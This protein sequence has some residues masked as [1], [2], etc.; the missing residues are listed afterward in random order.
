[1]IGSTPP[2]RVH[3]AN[4]APLRSDGDYVLYWMIS[5]RRAFDNFALQHA[6]HTAQ[7]LGKPLL[8]LEALRC[9][10]P[11]ASDRFHR[12]VLDGMNT[13]RG[14]FDHP[15]VLYYPYISAKPKQGKGL[16][17]LLA[18]HACM[19]VTDHFPC[20]FLPNMVAAAGRKLPIRLDV[21]DSN[22]V[23]PLS[24]APRVFTTAASFRRHLHKEILPHLGQMPA[25]SPLVGAQLVGSVELPARCQE[26]YPPAPTAL[27]N[28]TGSASLRDLPI[29]HS[30]APIVER[31]GA[32]AAEIAMSRFL[33]D[34]LPAYLDGRNQ[35]DK[36]VCSGL[37]SYLHWGHIGVHRVLRQLFENERW[38]SAR[39][40]DKPTGSRAGWWGMSEA[41][42]AFIDQL[43][44]WRELGYTFCH[45]RPDDYHQFESL[46]RW[47]LQTLETHAD[48]PREHLYSL[49]QLND[50][51]THD[52]LWNAAQRQLVEQ[53][54]IHN[55]LRMLWG[56][57]IL[58]WSPSP[59]V[60]LSHLIELNNR[61]SIDGRNPNSWSGIFWTLGRFDRAWGP[62]RAI[63]GK[64]R[65]MC[66]VNTA[67][68]VRVRPYLA[69][70]AAKGS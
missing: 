48:D 64:V 15:G 35:P 60:A 67:R 27:L 53:G 45:L 31:G 42:E 2:A 19:V 8:V 63:F 29:D 25:P 11:W 52:P 9:D 7:L 13:N 50:A 32:A 28:D 44:T 10:Y 18:A 51:Q 36:D 58:Q 69:Q 12:F 56:K 40:A 54:R 39:V 3:T 20:F 70:W 21:V 55:Y 57:K 17:E 41:A 16:L 66:S 38:T 34:R 5:A 6:V 49:T 23:M 14:D 33:S 4:Q 30:V 1:M 37:S 24:L 22:G 62:E 47:S 43:V 65:Y 61:Y 46:P 59:R 26:R 68:K